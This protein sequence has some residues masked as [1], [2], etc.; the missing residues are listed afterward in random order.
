MLNTDS[1]H[2]WLIANGFRRVTENREW[3]AQRGDVFIWGRMNYSGGAGGHTGIF[4]GHDN[5]IHCNYGNNGVTVNNY[6]A[7]WV[8]DGGPYF[9]AYRYAGTATQGDDDM[10]LSKLTGTVPVTA[11]GV[12]WI[13]NPNGAILYDNNRKATSRK[14]AYGTGWVV[15]SLE[16][17]WLQVGGL[18][19]PDDAVLKLNKGAV[20]DDWTGQVIQVTVG[21][22]YTQAKPTGGQAGIKYLPKGSRWKVIGATKGFVN[23]GGW[24][25][26]KKVRI[27]V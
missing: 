26:A 16:K 15:N 22:A 11:Y 21:D 1:L 5:I 8:A 9:Y 25:D 3:T 14:L 7:Y 4:I 12:A 18:I 19:R 20:S 27:E 13:T 23:I 6:D 17:G 2:T 10:D 24:V